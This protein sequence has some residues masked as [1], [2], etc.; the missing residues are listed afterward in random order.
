MQSFPL[1]STLGSEVHEVEAVE[2]LTPFGMKSEGEMQWLAK[3]AVQK[4]ER[5]KSPA[6][7]HAGQT[8]LFIWPVLPT[9]SVKPCEASS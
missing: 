6:Q 2:V 5:L 7:G 4:V 9:Y 1:D 3:R 8:D